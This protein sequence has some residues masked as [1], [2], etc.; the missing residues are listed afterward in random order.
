MVK[1]KVVIDRMTTDPKHTSVEAFRKYIQEDPPEIGKMAPQNVEFAELD[2]NDLM[3]KTLP[4]YQRGF[5]FN[6]TKALVQSM[7]NYGYM[8]ASLAVVVKRKDGSLD[9]HDARHRAVACYIL[10]IEKIP[11]VIVSFK[12]EADEINHFNTIN[13][14]RSG[15]KLEQQIM[16]GFQANDP[17]CMLI[18]DLGYMDTNSKWS[19]KVA[20]IGTERQKEKMTVTNFCKVVNWAGLGVRRRR[21]GSGANR[22]AAKMRVLNYQETLERMNLF[23]DWFYKFATPI[24]VQNDMFHKDK[25]LIS[26]LEFFYCALRQE[27]KSKYLSTTRILDSSVSMFRNYNFQMLNTYDAGTA[28]D[29]LFEHFNKK[30][31]KYPVKRI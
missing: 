31:G 24:R 13:A 18:Y 25:V 19:D 9:L 27:S 21:E 16:N 26:M 8:P 20:L 4:Q 10:G 2:V 3:K 15:T 29:K 22:V 12:N 6:R 30:R 1:R 7:I 17:Y 28:P 14:S 5:E 11:S 23:H